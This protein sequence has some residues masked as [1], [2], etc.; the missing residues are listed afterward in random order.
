VALEGLF[1]WLVT[2]LNEKGITGSS[3]PDVVAQLDAKAVTQTLRTL[4]GL[5][6]PAI[7]GS[8]SPSNLFTTFGVNASSLSEGTGRELDDAISADHPLAEPN[9]EAAIRRGSYLASPAGLAIPSILLALTLGRYRRWESS[10]YGDW[11]ASDAIVKDPYLDLLPSTVSLGLVRHL[12]D[13]WTLPWKKLVEF[14]LSRFIVQQHQSMSYEKTAKG[15][16]CLIQVD[17]QRISSD[18]PYETIGLVNGRLRS[19]V[20]VLIDLAL[21][22]PDEDGLPFV[23]EEGLQVLHEELTGRQET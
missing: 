1:S 4:F 13:W 8:S 14:V 16:R 10:E 11:L 5:D 9:L 19:A 7:F 2:Q 18:G 3:I 17:G 6:L 15:D 20:Q 23:T 21:I 12:G 22:K